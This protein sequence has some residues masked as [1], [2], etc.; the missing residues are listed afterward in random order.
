[1]VEDPTTIGAALP[2]IVEKL[3]Q[4]PDASIPNGEKRLDAGDP[5]VASA[6]SN[7]TQWIEKV[8]DSS[9]RPSTDTEM[10]FLDNEFDGCDVTRTEWD[11]DDLHFEV[12]QTLQTFALKIAPLDDGGTGDDA[13]GR[14]EFARDLCLKVFSRETEMR[15]WDATCVPVRD[16]EKKIAGWSFDRG[17][18]RELPEDKVVTGGTFSMMPA[19]KPDAKHLHPDQ[20]EEP[21]VDPTETFEAYYYWFRNVGWWNDGRYVGFFFPKSEGIGARPVFVGAEIGR[22]WFD[23]PRDRMGHPFRTPSQ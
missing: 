22:R 21:P 12:S 23:I 8:L 19:G 10:L 11:R 6:R 20:N 3:F 13:E 2:T 15:Q 9:V 16:L 5:V 14:F 4:W 18:M 7:S 1:M 17:K